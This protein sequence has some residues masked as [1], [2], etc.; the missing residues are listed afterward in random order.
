MTVNAATVVNH[1][2]AVNPLALRISVFRSI[3]GSP[4]RLKGTNSSNEAPS[5]RGNRVAYVRDNQCC[6]VANHDRSADGSSNGVS[7]SFIRGLGRKSLD[8]LA[9]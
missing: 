5:R 6:S 4:Q 2:T 8:H 7:G 1:D 9:T 3:P